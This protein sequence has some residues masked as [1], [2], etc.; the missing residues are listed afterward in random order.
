MN[1]KEY[2]I[3]GI[4]LIFTIVMIIAIVFNTE[5]TIR[6]NNFDMISNNYINFVSIL[7]GFLITTISIVMGFFDKK[8]IK[9]IVQSKKDKILYINWFVAIIMGILSI[10]MM[11]FVVATYDETEKVIKIIPFCIIIALVSLF[12]GYLIFSL[13]YFFIIAKSVMKENINEK[14]K[15]VILEKSNIKKPS[16]IK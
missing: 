4:P 12:I 10:L 16:E 5:E 11:F 1:K 13:M 7:V 14:E 9:I 6:V 15:V 2:F 8:I 3:L